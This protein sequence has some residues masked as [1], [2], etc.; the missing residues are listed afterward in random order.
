[1]SLLEEIKAKAATKGKT[2]VL[3]EGTE[4]RT[5]LAIKDIVANNS[6]SHSSR[7]CECC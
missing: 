3:P 5:L 7:Q 4:K 2:I 1:M 6:K